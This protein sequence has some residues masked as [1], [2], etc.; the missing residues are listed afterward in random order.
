MIGLCGGS[1][2]AG[3][4]SNGNV[5]S[6]AFVARVLALISRMIVVQNGKRESEREKVLWFCFL[7]FFELIVAAFVACVRCS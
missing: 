4:T 6:L 2:G 3:A 7:L 5:S 1:R